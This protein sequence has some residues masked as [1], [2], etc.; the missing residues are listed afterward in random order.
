MDDAEIRRIV[1][2]EV[3]RRLLSFPHPLAQHSRSHKMGGADALPWG[4][5]GLLDVDKLDGYDAGELLSLFGNWTGD[6]S[7]ATDYILA[8]CVAHDG[9]SYVCIVAHT[10]YEPP[11]VV[12]WDLL[13]AEGEKGDTGDKGDQG[14]TGDTGSTGPQGEKGDQ[15]EMGLIG[16][17]EGSWS[18]ETAYIVGNTV[19]YEGSSYVCIVAN[20]GQLPTDESYWNMTASKGDTGTGVGIFWDSFQ[21]IHYLY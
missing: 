3:D 2:E 13:A 11:N 4:S 14:D 17:W 5:N 10:N 12:Y 19:E 8:D 20:T 16:T 21:L 18:V 15:G 1:S 9:S 6:W 7:S